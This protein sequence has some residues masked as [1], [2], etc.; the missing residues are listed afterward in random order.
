M[1]WLS[2]LLDTIPVKGQV[3]IRC[4]YSAPWRVDFESLGPGEIPYHVVMR[5]TALI[6][7]AVGEAEERLNAGDIV[8]LPDGAPHVLRDESRPPPLAARSR[9]GLNLVVSEND[10]EGEAL[11]MLCG[12]FVLTPPY[13]RL[14]LDYLPERLIVRAAGPERAETDAAEDALGG[15]VGLMQSESIADRLGGRALLNALSTALFAMVLRTSSE[16]GDAPRGLSALAS[17]PRLT[18]A[19]TA[20]FEDPARPW[21]LPELAGLCHM[22]RA[23]MAR[24]FK[25]RV[26]RSAAELLTDIRMTLAARALRDG[27]A[28]TA[29]VA[30]SVGYQSEAAFQ[31]AFKQVMGV[32]PA[33]WRR[34]ERPEGRIR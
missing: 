26:G 8:L 27:A 30:E 28:S 31:R 25:D 21:T 10:G 29:T 34:T 14:I 9:Q 17:D 15:L 19:L 11:E 12:R 2:R 13:D 24:R 5:G 20:M 3:D 18:P 33:V 7:T 22:S 4:S 6:A 32:T 1:D 23:T 16:R